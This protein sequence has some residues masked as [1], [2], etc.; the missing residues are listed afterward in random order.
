MKTIEILAPNI[1]TNTL[2]VSQQFFSQQNT[3]STSQFIVLT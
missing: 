1:L 3:A 2:D